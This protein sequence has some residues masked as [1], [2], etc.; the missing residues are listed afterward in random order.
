MPEQVGFRCLEC[1]HGF[2]ID[3]LSEGEAA[4]RRRRQLPVGPIRCP[5]CGSVKVRRVGRAA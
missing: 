2:V 4:D 1:G 3:V 5:E